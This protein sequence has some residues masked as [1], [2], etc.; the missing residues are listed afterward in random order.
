MARAERG[1]GIS[2]CVLSTSQ[3]FRLITTKCLPRFR[4]QHRIWMS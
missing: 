2:C 4:L 1:A 3:W